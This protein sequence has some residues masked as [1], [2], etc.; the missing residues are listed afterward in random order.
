MN[1]RLE[2]SAYWAFAD[3]LAIFAETETIRLERGRSQKL[4]GAPPR[5]K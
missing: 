4:R 3:Q 1:G 5:N 2:T